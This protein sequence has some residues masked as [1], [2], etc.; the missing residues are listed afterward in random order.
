MTVGW[1]RQRRQCPAAT[2]TITITII[3]LTV[4]ASPSTQRQSLAP[5][6]LLVPGRQFVFPTRRL[7]PH[8]ALLKPASLR[9]LYMNMADYPYDSFPMR[10][11]KIMGILSD[12]MYCDLKQTSTT[13]RDLIIIL[14]LMCQS[15][16][17]KNKPASGT[18][19]S[20]FFLLFFFT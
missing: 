6:L 20:F 19:S 5:P 13:L 14:K 8:L 16:G 12:I 17:G 4:L 1:Y 10:Y 15:H 9:T 3:I 18:E 7:P 2:P 11:V